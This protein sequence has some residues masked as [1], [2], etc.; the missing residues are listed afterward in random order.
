MQQENLAS[1]EYIE[2]PQ[3]W[4]YVLNRRETFE[5]LPPKEGCI[6]FVGDSITQRN[7]WAEMFDN[8]NIIN[9]GIDSD[10]LTWLEHRMPNLLANKPAKIFI[11]IG[12]NDIMD[13]KRAKQ[14]KEEYQVILKQFK[15]LEN[16]QVYVQSCLPVNNTEYAHPID[17]TVVQSVNKMLE[18][19]VSSYSYTY[20]NLYNHFVNENN[21]LKSDYTRDGVHLNGIGY[22][23][24]K[25]QIKEYI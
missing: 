1:E 18:E 8:P 12:I 17:N 7:E 15:S 20:I 16:C 25:D 4:P 11:K 24:W 22:L 5:V 3:P 23:V 19:L 21:E 2:S 9:R 13:G 6:M 10:R 14:M